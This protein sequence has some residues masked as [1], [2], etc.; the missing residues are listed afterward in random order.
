MNETVVLILINVAFGLGAFRED[1]LLRWHL[2]TTW[3]ERL[4]ALALYAAQACFPLLALARGHAQ[5]KQMLERTVN[6]Y[7]HSATSQ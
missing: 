7:K 5:Y 6:K 3:M 4:H 2:G 1:F